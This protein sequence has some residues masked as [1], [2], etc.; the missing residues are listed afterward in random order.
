M[1][2]A[3]LMDDSCHCR[4]CATGVLGCNNSEDNVEASLL[5]HVIQEK[6]IM[7]MVTSS[8]NEKLRETLRK[9]FLKDIKEI[10]TP[11]EMFDICES[12]GI[13]QKG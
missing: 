4:A 5:Q 2:K 8:G 11:K 6:Q 1:N 3:S 9:H 7:E 12:A 10:V 13:S